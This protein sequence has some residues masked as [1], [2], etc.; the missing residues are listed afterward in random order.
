M[1]KWIISIRGRVSDRAD[2]DVD[3][4]GDAEA[5]VWEEPVSG[6]TCLAGNLSHLSW[7]D[8]NNGPYIYISSV[9]APTT[10]GVKNNFEHYDAR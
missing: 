4:D 9:G 10:H 2:Y 3:Q 6:P 8:P 5:F 1:K 7:R